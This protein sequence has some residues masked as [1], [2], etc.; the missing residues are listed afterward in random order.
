MKAIRV[1]QDVP[2]GS[3]VKNPPAHAGETGSISGLGRSHMPQGQ[4]THAPQLLSPS[5]AATT[6]AH[7]APELVARKRNHHDRSPHT[8]T[9]E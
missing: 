5:R 1:Y 8:V 2:G 9:R 7:C 6:E 3:V 4:K